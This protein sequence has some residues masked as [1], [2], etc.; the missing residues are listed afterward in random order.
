M[1]KRYKRERA[2]AMKNNIAAEYLNV[3]KCKKQRISKGLLEEIIQKHQNKRR[4]EDIPATGFI[5]CR[6]SFFVDKQTYEIF[7]N[8]IFFSI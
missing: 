6:H 8:F 5:F 4:L 3:K 7:S 1:N 2:I